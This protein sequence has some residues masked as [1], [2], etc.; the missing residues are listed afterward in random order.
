MSRRPPSR[1]SRLGGYPAF[2]GSIVAI[3]IMILLGILILGVFFSN[4]NPLMNLNAQAYSVYNYLKTTVANVMPL[5][6][7]LI[8]I[9]VIG[10]LIIAIFRLD[11]GSEY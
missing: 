10:L 6:G 7:V 4:I 8:F 5:L 9:S 11:L 2:F 1:P 3:A